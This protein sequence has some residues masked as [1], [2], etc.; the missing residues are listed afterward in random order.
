MHKLVKEIGKVTTR[1]IDSD[2]KPNKNQIIRILFKEEI[3]EQEQDKLRQAAMMGAF[4]DK[5]LSLACNI[6]LETLR[7]YLKKH[8]KFADELAV[9]SGNVVQLARG[10]LVEQIKKGSTDVSKWW[11]E[12]HP[13]SEFNPKSSNTLLDTPLLIILDSNNNPINQLDVKEGEIVDE[14]TSRPE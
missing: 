1:D 14:Q 4:S 2:I 3:N 5:D 10:N 8:Q 7:E 13:N 6:D 11:L 12:K 9:L